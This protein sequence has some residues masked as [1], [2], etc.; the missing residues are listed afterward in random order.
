MLCPLNP[1]LIKDADHFYYPLTSSPHLLSF[2]CLKKKKKTI[3][4][5][6]KLVATCLSLLVKN[7]NN[8][9]NPY[10]HLMNMNKAW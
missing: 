8:P 10:Q 5:A 6:N 3:L 7:L 4:L 2:F 9:C 1:D